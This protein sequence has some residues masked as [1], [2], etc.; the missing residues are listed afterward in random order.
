ME[1]LKISPGEFED[2]VR[3]WLKRSCRKLVKFDVRRRETLSGQGGEY[4]ID[5]LVELEI[6]DG[7]L[8]R[9]LVEC[10]RHKNPIKRDLVMVLDSK[11]RDVAAHKGVI[12]ST[13]GFQRGAVKY[14]KTHGIAAVRVAGVET[15]YLAKAEG[16]RRPPRTGFVGWFTTLEQDDEPCEKLVDT[17][18][19]KPLQLWLNSRATSQRA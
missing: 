2:P 6:F 18:Y 1:L 3:T 4:E 19:T 5:I 16:A 9:V 11:L 14:A 13:S 8:I 17:E 7:A 15:T 12:F 10:K